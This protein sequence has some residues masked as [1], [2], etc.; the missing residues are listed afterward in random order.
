[1]GATSSA[2]EC[3]QCPP[4]RDGIGPWSHPSTTTATS[5]TPSKRACRHWCGGNP[6]PL[7]CTARRLALV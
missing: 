3:N 6:Q 5:W 7:F 4:D 1:V 2:S